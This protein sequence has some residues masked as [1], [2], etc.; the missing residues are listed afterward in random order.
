MVLTHL[1]QELHAAVKPGKKQILQNFFKTG[2]DQYAEGDVF[3]GV[4]V[5]DAR[6]VARQFIHLPEGEIRTL[7]K[8]KV[9]EERLV[10]L[11]ILVERF[12]QA[13]EKKR[14]EI[15]NFY[16][17]HLDAVNNWDLVDLTAPKIV[18]DFFLTKD[19]GMLYHLAYSKTVWERRIAI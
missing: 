1:R 19:R 7:L 15:I 18:G 9:H 12:Q 10:A 8:S 17:M 5:P 13:E 16:W 11:L 2:P 6:R 3:L 14:Q 4:M